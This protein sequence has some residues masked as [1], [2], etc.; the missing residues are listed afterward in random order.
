LA[1]LLVLTIVG[2]R[3][4]LARVLSRSRRTR[5]LLLTATALVVGGLAVSIGAA[6][7]GVRIAGVGLL[8]QAV[9]LL[10]FDVAD[11]R[12]GRRV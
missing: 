10:R 9:W 2:E 5:S 1:G 7:T 4:E 6:R 11:G 3:L 8:A 12:F